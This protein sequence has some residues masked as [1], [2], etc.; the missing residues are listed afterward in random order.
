MKRRNFIINS[1]LAGGAMVAGA[2]CKRTIS[3]PQIDRSR[4]RKLLTEQKVWFG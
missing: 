1:L 3:S 4:L 2:G